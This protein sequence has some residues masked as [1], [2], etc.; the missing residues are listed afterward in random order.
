MV[1]GETS[2]WSAGGSG[3]GVARNIVVGKFDQTR[4]RLYWP[5]VVEAAK[6]N[7]TTNNRSYRISV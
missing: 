3:P 5:P 4:F 6:G 2:L 1:T 7:P